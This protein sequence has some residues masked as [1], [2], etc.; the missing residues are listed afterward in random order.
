MKPNLQ[1]FHFAV[2]LFL[3]GCTYH[4]DKNA[5]YDTSVPAELVNKVSFQDVNTRVFATSCTPCHGSSGGVNLETYQSAKQNLES[6]RQ[7]V[8]IERRMPKAPYAPLNR[9]QLEILSAW[10]QAGGPEFPIEQQPPDTPELEAKFASIKSL[11]LDVKCLRCHSVGG[12]AERVPLTSLEEILNSPLDIV[13]PGNPDESGLILVLQEDARKP[14]P[15]PSSGISRVKPEEVEVIK[16]WILNG[17][18]E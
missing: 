14:M 9:E 4:I 8:L 17:A 11:I 10:I 2:V 15:P 12:T 3:G 7:A 5:P 16:Q 13:L 1:L 18:K 6:I